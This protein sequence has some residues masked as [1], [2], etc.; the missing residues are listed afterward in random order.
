VKKHDLVRKLNLDLE[1]NDLLEHPFYKAWA[2]GQLSRE[3]LQ[4][5]A[6]HYYPQIAAFPAQLSALHTRLPDGETRRPFC[7]ISRTRR[8][9]ECAILISGSTSLRGW[10]WTG[11]S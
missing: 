11:T 1:E 10:E 6:C 3:D 4:N 8:S 5:Y 7:G 2:A 9:T